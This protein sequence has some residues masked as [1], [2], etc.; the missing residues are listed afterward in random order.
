MCG[1][2]ACACFFPWVP[3]L[4]FWR[5]G[6]RAS[7]RSSVCLSLSFLFFFCQRAS[8]IVVP[9]YRLARRRRRGQN[10]RAPDMCARMRETPQ[11]VLPLLGVRIDCFAVGA[12]MAADRRHSPPASWISLSWSRWARPP[13]PSPF[14]FIFEKAP[15]L[16]RARGRWFRCGLRS[17]ACFLWLFVRLCVV[18][19]VVSCARELRQTAQQPPHCGLF[20]F[21]LAPIV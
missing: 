18:C 16:S 19:G 11:S 1:L 4:L 5:L 9:A 20:L 6:A 2:R 21:P 13:V 3:P 10:A 8:P 12:L 17:F 7:L 15:S 14:S